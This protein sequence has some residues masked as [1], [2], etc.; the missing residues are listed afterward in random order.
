MLNLDE[1]HSV[2]VL[3]VDNN[4]FVCLGFII[5]SCLLVG[6]YFIPGSSAGNHFENSIDAFV[7]ISNSNITLLA[8]IGNLFSIALF[9]FFGNFECEEKTKKENKKQ[10][11]LV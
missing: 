6:M 9:N 1:I 5:L 7:Q 11:K 2:G 10:K 4:Y 3:C 8:L